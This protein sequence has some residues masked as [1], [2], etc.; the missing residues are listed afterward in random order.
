MKVLYSSSSVK[1]CKE[2]KRVLKLLHK[3]FG[4]N[5]IRLR[6]K[7]WF[8]VPDEQRLVDLVNTGCKLLPIFLLS[9]LRSFC[10]AL[11]DLWSLNGKAILMGWSSGIWCCGSA[12]SCEGMKL[13]MVYSISRGGYFNFRNIDLKLLR[14]I[15]GQYLSHGSQYSMCWN[16]VDNIEWI[17]PLH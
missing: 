11:A 3:E 12:W 2:L 13:L 15:R 8:Y 1:I 7:F 6:V 16:L 14:E 10:T 4:A 9:S 5:W 17:P